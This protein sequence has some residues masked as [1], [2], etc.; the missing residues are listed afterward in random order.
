MVGKKTGGR[1]AGTPNKITIELRKTLKGIVANELELLPETLGDLP[2][3]ERLELLI[4]LLPFCLPKVDS[5]GGT[6]DTGWRD[7]GDED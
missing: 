6:Y 4:K 3:K 5:I 7:L 2:P 1:V